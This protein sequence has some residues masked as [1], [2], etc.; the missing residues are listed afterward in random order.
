MESFAYKIDITSN[1]HSVKLFYWFLEAC[2]WTRRDTTG[3][4]VD[5]LAHTPVV[6]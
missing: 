2:A 4:S 5:L 1:P 3:S 6:A